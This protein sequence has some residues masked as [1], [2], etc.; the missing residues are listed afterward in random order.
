MNLQQTAWLLSFAYI[1][2]EYKYNALFFISLV[3]CNNILLGNGIL[4]TIFQSE[5]R[6][7]L[8]ELGLASLPA[9]HSHT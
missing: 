5:L 8:Y 7:D 6:A 2:H 4:H 3:V 9:C 1:L